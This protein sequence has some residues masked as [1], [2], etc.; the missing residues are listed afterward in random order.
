MNVI[1]IRQETLQRLKSLRQ[2]EDG[3]YDAII[4]RLIGLPRATL[5]K[6]GRK[7][8]PELVMPCETC[9][10]TLKPVGDGLETC[11]NCNTTRPIIAVYTN[12]KATIIIKQYLQANTNKPITIDEISKTTGILPAQIEHVLDKLSRT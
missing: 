3:S 10:Q 4:R 5:K 9:G 6:R 11:T 1:K 2:T 12:L 8:M 7:P